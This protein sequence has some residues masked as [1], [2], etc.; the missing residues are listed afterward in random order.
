MSFKIE[1]NR[2]QL[3]NFCKDDYDPYRKMTE[4]PQYQRYYSEDDCSEEK[5]KELISLFIRQAGQ[6]N[7]QAYQLAVI[8]KKTGQFI[9]T[10]GLRMETGR[11]T[12]LGCGL[13]CDFQGEG[14]AEEAVQA[15]IGFWNR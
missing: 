12:S 6:S 13:N 10:C 5:A 11:Q 1:T 8:L 15:M 14:F 4:H 3:R 9:G 7:R 2:L